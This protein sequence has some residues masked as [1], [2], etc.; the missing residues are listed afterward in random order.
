[1]A[2]RDDIQNVS[3]QMRVPPN[4]FY[5]TENEFNT[6]IDDFKNLE[7]DKKG[8]LFMYSLQQV[9]FESTNNNSVNNTYSIFLAFLYKHE[10]D[11][12]NSNQIEPIDTMVVNSINE[13]LVRLKNY[14]GANGGKVFKI[15]V[16]DKTKPKPVY[17]NYADVNLYGRGFALDLPTF[18][19]DKYC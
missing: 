10:F 17:F 15:D 11:T 5:G 3:T 6:A 2:L 13:F 19:N 12:Q 1:M 14:R 8:V 16:G 9:N 4:F 18:Y 7:L